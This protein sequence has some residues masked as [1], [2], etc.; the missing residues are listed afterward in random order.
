MASSTPVLSIQSVEASK[1]HASDI[2]SIKSFVE[3][4]GLSTIP[5]NYHS[6]ID[7]L[8]REV[9]DELGAF[10]PVIDFSFITSDD[11]QFHGK[12]VQELG[13]ACEEWGLFMADQAPALC[14]TCL[15]KLFGLLV[16]ST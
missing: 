5:P 6:L 3:S 16:C 13:R 14:R 4:N 7:P 12:G 8:D 11:P 2:T 10:I 9:A 1:D 15:G